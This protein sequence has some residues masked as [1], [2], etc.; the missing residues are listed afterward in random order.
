MNQ[1]RNVFLTLVGALALYSFSHLREVWNIDPNYTIRFEATQASGNFSGLSGTIQYDPDDLAASKI[2]VSVDVN[3]I[4]T[5]NKTK[6]SHA[7]GE[8][9]FDAETYPQIRFTSLSFSSED[10]QSVVVGILDLRGIKKEVKIPYTF[11]QNGNKAVF[12]GEFQVNRK[13]Y[14][15]DGGFTQFVVGDVITVKLEIPVSKK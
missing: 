12:K 4:D 13:D 7:K 8:N 10:S 9:W 3:S 2:Q 11:D 15:I 1:I 5:G 14:G 6:N